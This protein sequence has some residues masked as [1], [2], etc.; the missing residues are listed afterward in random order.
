MC[1]FLKVKYQVFFHVFFSLLQ[2]VS[3][4]FLASQKIVARSV[5]LEPLA[6]WMTITST[7]S[8]D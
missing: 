1:L 3:P 5:F 4:L 8:G 6:C 7:V 2:N